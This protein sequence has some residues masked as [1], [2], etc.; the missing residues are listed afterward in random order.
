MEEV[1]N[2]ESDQKKKSVRSQQMGD[3][4]I[5]RFLREIDNEEE[6]YKQRLIKIEEFKRKKGKV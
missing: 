2:C 3:F 5:A 1:K 4:S 6:R